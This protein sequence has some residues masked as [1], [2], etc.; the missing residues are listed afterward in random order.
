MTEEMKRLVEKGSTKMIPSV[1]AADFDEEEII[2]EESTEQIE[3][4]NVEELLR[5]LKQQEEEIQKLKKDKQPMASKI[6]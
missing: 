1:E 5:K 4:E 6:N 3:Q 2:N